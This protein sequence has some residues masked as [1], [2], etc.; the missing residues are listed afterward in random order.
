[1]GGG[2]GEGR[3]PA[4]SW[5]G[6]ATVVAAGSGSAPGGC[7]QPSPK[8]VNAFARSIFF[9]DTPPNSPPPPP[10]KKKIPLRCHGKGAVVTA[11]SELSFLRKPQMSKAGEKAF[12]LREGGKKKI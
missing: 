7:C 10:P 5:W 11:A 6:R 1:M 4:A 9:R 12:V 8:K 3:V 2:T